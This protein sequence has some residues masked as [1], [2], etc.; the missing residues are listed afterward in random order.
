MPKGNLTDLFKVG[1]SPQST[2]TTNLPCPLQVHP[3]GPL[4]SWKT[5]KPLYWKLWKKKKKNTFHIDSQKLK[6]GSSPC[7]TAMSSVSALSDWLGLRSC[8]TATQ[9]PAGSV[10]I[11]LFESVHSNIKVSWHLSGIKILFFHKV[12]F[13][14][15]LIFWFNTLTVVTTAYVREDSPGWLDFHYTDGWS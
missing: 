2:E 8:I 11:S 7:P 13:G 6:Q 14:V 15:G 9:F 10:I 1:G 4:S 5:T 12:Y 3:Q